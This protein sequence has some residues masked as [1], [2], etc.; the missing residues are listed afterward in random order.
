[1]KEFTCERC[2]K[3]IDQDDYCTNFELRDDC[4]EWESWMRT[5]GS[6]L[7]GIVVSAVI[8]GFCLL[9]HKTGCCNCRYEDNADTTNTIYSTGG[10]SMLPFMAN[11][12]HNWHPANINHIH[13]R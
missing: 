8:V 11:P 12:V 6:W 13:H 9:G 5:V 10:S 2:G 3:Q 1:V 7:V 4:P